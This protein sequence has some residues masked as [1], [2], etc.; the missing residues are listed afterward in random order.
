MSIALTGDESLAVILWLLTVAGLLAYS[1]F[2]SQHPQ[3]A[4]ASQASGYSV[5]AIL[6]IFLSNEKAEEAY[7]GNINNVP[8]AIKVLAQETAKPFVYSRQFHILVLSIMWKKT[9]H[10]P[11][12]SWE[13]IL[14]L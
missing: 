13:P 2:Y 3:L 11:I 12:N 10:S 9:I 4:Y 14:Y 6:T 8:R 5:P 7:N 1:K